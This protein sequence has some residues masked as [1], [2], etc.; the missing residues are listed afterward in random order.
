MVEALVEALIMPIGLDLA[1]KFAKMV[2]L[3]ELL[4]HMAT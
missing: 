3:V 2:D 4:Q 1:G